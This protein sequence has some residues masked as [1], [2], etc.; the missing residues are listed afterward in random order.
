MMEHF[1]VKDSF[2]TRVGVEGYEI[3]AVIR[4]IGDDIAVVFVEIFYR[5]W[6]AIDSSFINL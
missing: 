6:G 4:P 5:N 1:Q 2:R 3:D